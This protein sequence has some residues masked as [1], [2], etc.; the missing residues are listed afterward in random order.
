MIRN[1]WLDKILSLV[2]AITLWT[3]VQAER[4]PQ[5]QKIFTVN[6]KA[7]SGP[8]RGYEAELHTQQ[9]TVTVHGAKA[10]VETIGPQNVGAFVD[11]SHI[12]TGRNVEVRVRPVIS[13][14]SDDERAALE[15]PNVS[16]DT[17]KVSIEATTEKRLPVEIKFLTAPPLG[18][19]YGSPRIDPASVRVSGK[20]SEVSKIRRVVL[21][22]A[23]NTSK[24]PI[25][26]VFDL[27]PVD[28]NGSV[29]NG[30]KLDPPSAQLHVQLIE[31]P[32]T[33]TVLVSPNI[34]GAPGYPAVVNK[35]AVNPTTVVLEGK[36]MVLSELS[37]I[38][39]DKIAI[40]NADNTISKDVS[41]RLPAG[42]RIVGRNHVRVTV[43]IGTP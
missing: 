20:A 33:K 26:D 25:D 9:V 43:N 21:P 1:N 40:D 23:G 30:V 39:T 31:V 17:I 24:E 8:A 10:S 36:P 34:T 29:V 5:G 41:L 11:L 27:I 16:P 2:V 13:G 28:Y 15:A 22:L 14:L 4:N 42:V 37:T 35:V 6:V 7:S 3:Y 32:A 38:S 18:Y 19:A 12:R